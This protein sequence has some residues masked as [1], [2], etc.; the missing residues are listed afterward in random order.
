MIFAIS[1]HFVLF[2]RQNIGNFV[3]KTKQRCGYDTK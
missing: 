3:P 1:L 2:A